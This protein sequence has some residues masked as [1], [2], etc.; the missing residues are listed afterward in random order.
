MECSIALF[1]FA[2]DAKVLFRENISSN[3]VN[4][5]LF[6]LSSLSTVSNAFSFRAI[7]SYNALICVM[8]FEFNNH[9]L[10][11]AVCNWF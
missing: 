1:V 3:L 4:R 7:S 9:A 2:P 6:S 11:D 8:I 10:F 5:R